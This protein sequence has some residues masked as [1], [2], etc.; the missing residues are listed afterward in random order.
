MNAGIKYATRA[1]QA[2]NA[3]LATPG[4]PGDFNDLHLAQGLEAVRHRIA[5]ARP[6]EGQQKMLNGWPVPVSL[7]L[8][9][10]P[11]I[12]PQSICSLREFCEAVAGSVQVPFDLVAICAIGAVAAAAQGKFCVLIRPGY[13][14]PLN[15]YAV[16]PLP[17]AERKSSGLEPCKR[18]L[19]DWEAEQARVMA[20]EISL[21]R[22]ERATKEKTIE[23]LRTRATPETLDE[24][25]RQVQKLEEDLPEIPDAPRVLI[26]DTTPEAL[27]AFMSRQGGTAAI[28]EA[29]GGIF[30][31]LSGL[32]TNGRANL[33]LILKAW[34]GESVTVDRRSR[35]TIMLHNPCLTI[36]LC[37]QP[38]VLREIAAKPGFRGKGV[39]GRF[40]YCMPKSLLGRRP[41]ETKPV[42]EAVTAA[43]RA[44]ILHIL[45]TPHALNEFGEP[46]P[47]DLKLSDEAYR[48]WVAFSERVESELRAGGEFENIRDWA[49]KLPGQ[50]V[51]LAGIL[52]VAAETKPAHRS[53]SESTMAA[54]LDLAA[55]L[56]DHALLAF[57]E[58]GADPAIE[59]AKRILQW[60]M[61]AQ[62]TEFP[63]RDAFNAVKGRYPKMDMIRQGLRVLEDRE[64][65][66][67]VVDQKSPG[68][69]R[70]PSPVFQVNPLAHNS[71]NSQK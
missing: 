45:E 20:P 16:V 8:H 65:V 71:H 22:S 49:G 35:G 70:K 36:C 47:F 14:E 58:M 43:Y 41:V 9:S 57:A 30:E 31:I 3:D 13:R 25:I 21:K 64:Y 29:E 51:R 68:P 28:M 32:Y 27:A 63:A 67:L 2:V 6:P 44:M 26:D 23:K 38:E 42:P 12:P 66:R 10:A 24:S 1:A 37:I 34:C 17:P 40:L 52:H 55:V 53:I 7:E 15:I 46:Q 4:Q 39:L 48:L 62:V 11:A 56:A 61:D 60:F 33:N 59:C 18:P 50:A 69:G 5:E 54:A 19:V